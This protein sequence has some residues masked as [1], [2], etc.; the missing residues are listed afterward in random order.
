LLKLYLSL[1]RPKQNLST[2]YRP[3]ETLSQ[4]HTDMLENVQKSLMISVNKG[5][6]MWRKTKRAGYHNTGDEKTACMET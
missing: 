4:K 2:V 1:V 5:G 6:N 3:I